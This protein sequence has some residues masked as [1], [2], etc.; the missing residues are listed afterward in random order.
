MKIAKPA[1]AGSMEAVTLGDYLFGEEERFSSGLCEDETIR[2]QEAV[3][4]SFSRFIF[5][6]TVLH[7]VTWPKVELTDV[8]FE[9]C[10]LS[11]VDFSGALLHR[12]EFIDSKMVGAIFTDS[13][14]R[15]TRFQGCNCGYAQFRFTNWKE[16]VLE[17]TML[18]SADFTESK[19]T[20]L[21]LNGCK[22]QQAEFLRT[23]MTGI[24]LSTCEI[25]GISIPLENL[26]GCI[27]SQEQAAIFAQY[28]GLVIRE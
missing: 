5:R 20:K 18:A 26:K 22:L 16:A 10:D 23:N 12:V 15:N 8:R 27:I 14:F 17:D 3:S 21:H 7:Q 24:D 13:T 19:L 6:R 11:N 9:G 25:E 1:F 28:L 4:V 2:D